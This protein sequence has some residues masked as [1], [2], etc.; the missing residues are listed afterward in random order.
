MKEK[1]RPMGGDRYLQKGAT[2]KPKARRGHI[3]E[4]I[5]EEERVDNLSSDVLREE[6]MS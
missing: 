2:L 3:H 1:K 5:A 4:V 6:S